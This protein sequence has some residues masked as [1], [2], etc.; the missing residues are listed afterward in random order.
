MK[1]KNRNIPI[2]N[3]KIDIGYNINP[4]TKIIN[5]VINAIRQNITSF[6]LFGIN[7]KNSSLLVIKIK[8]FDN[9]K[10]IFRLKYL[11]KV[12]KYQ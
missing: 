4:I 12:K 2:I 3:N 5:E 6:F 1:N 10:I 9:N 7:I 8:Y 11:V